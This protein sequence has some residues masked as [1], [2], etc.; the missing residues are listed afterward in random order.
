[1]IMHKNCIHYASHN[2]T[3]IEKNIKKKIKLKKVFK[4]IVWY[5]SFFHTFFIMMFYT[6]TIPKYYICNVSY[7]NER[8]TVR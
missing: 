3:K 4:Q 1:M 8:R 2:G 5:E 6:K 7:H